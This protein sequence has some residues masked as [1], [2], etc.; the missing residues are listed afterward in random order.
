MNTETFYGYS[1]TTQTGK[2]GENAACQYLLEKG[3]L[4]LATNYRVG[5]KE[6]DI[7]AQD[8]QRLVF[9]EVKTRRENSLIMPQD[10]VH[11]LKQI[12]IIQAAR[13]YIQRTH[14]KSEGRFDIICVQKS[15]LGIFHVTEHIKEAFFP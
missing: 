4:I 12:F 7:I 11:R 15:P 1:S 5:H 6:I 8:N 3:Y 13:A 10:A 14:N 9:V 2:I